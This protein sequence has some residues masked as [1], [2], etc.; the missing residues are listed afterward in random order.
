MNIKTDDHRR[1][2]E[3]KRINERMGEGEK[4]NRNRE[5]YEGK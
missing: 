4:G 2:R 3:K 1:R 5:V